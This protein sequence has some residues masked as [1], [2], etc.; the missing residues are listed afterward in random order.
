MLGLIQVTAYFEFVNASSTIQGNWPSV[1]DRFVEVEVA[2]GVHRAVS[3]GWVQPY[4][5]YV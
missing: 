2:S 3:I 5:S 1:V 4:A